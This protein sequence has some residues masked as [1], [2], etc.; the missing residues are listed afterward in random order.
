MVCH[1]RND[2]A[3]TSLLSQTHT[4]MYSCRSSFIVDFPV[5]VCS[6]IQVSKRLDYP[7]SGLIQHTCCTRGD[8]LVPFVQGNQHEWV[9]V[10]AAGVAAMM[11]VTAVAFG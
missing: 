9:V 10:A 2:T 5:F 8:G 4:H 6:F 7:T 1:A 3:N 11:M